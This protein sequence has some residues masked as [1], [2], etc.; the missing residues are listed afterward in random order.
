MQMVI[1]SDRL[2]ARYDETYVEPTSEFLPVIDGSAGLQDGICLRADNLNVQAAKQREGF[3]T[4]FHCQSGRVTAYCPRI[5]P[6][7]LLIII[8]NIIL[9]IILIMVILIL[10]ILSSHISILI[11]IILIIQFHIRP[12]LPP[13]ELA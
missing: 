10:I 9:T 4:I 5:I 6:I 1:F 13:W 7:S 11:L 2:D 3:T 8:F 12:F